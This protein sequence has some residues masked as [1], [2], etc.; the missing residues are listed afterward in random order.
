MRLDLNPKTLQLVYQSYLLY[1][2]LG[3]AGIMKSNLVLLVFAVRRHSGMQQVTNASLA[4]WPHF[5][6]RT[7]LCVCPVW[8]TVSTAPDHNHAIFAKPIILA[9]CVKPVRLGMCSTEIFLL[10]RSASNNSAVTE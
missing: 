4:P 8:L 9:K 5:Q 7:R 1:Q 10:P 6:Y 3:N 2:C